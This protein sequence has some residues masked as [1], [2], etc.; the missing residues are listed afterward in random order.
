[1]SAVLTRQQVR[2]RIDLLEALENLLSATD[3]VSS[4]EFDPGER[5]DLDLSINARDEKKSPVAFAHA[6]PQEVV[7]AG[8]QA[9]SG[10]LEA[11]LWEAAI[12]TAKE[13]AA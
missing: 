9:M 7:L 4:V 1:M 13:N 10:K 6:L 12:A 5:H 3:D 11:L 8:L 2:Q